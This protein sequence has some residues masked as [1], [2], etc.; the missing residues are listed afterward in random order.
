MKEG[1][2]QQTELVCVST[3]QRE[4]VLWSLSGLTGR[5]DEPRGVR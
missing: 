2:P 5:I 1:L 3:R 4:A